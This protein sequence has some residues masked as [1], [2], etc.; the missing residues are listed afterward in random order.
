MTA[1]AW[2]GRVGASSARAPEGCS[3]R[4]LV[5]LLGVERPA[6]DR[7]VVDRRVRPQAE[8]EPDVTELEVEVD[9]DRRAARIRERDGEVAGGEGLARCRPS[10]R[11]R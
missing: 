11:G 5:D 4:K 8:R 3:V 9:D 10:G 7:E 2:S 1:A 6:G